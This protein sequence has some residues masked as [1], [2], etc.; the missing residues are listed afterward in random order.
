LLTWG[1][2]DS[3]LISAFHGARIPKIERI[4]AIDSDK[5]AALEGRGFRPISFGDAQ[6]A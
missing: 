4:G 2:I 1:G 6:W 5:K 3:V